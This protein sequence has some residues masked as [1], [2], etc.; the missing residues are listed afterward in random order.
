MFYRDVIGVPLEHSE[1]H[2]PENVEHYET[3][4][5]EWCDH[6]PVEPYLWLNLFASRDRITSGAQL[7]FPVPNL[8]AVLELAAQSGFAIV[9]EPID[10]PWGRS[11]E[12]LD[13]DGNFVTVTER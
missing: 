12:L 7:S 2:Q 4:W 3:M 6:G 11:A 10:V 9:G 5:G 8:S 1:P 13:P